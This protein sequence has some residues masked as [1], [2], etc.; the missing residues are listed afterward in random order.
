MSPAP[1]TSVHVRSRALVIRSHA[2]ALMFAV[3]LVATLAAFAAAGP[4]AS[5][6]GTW[7]VSRTAT[8]HDYIAVD[9]IDLL[10]GWAVYGTN[11]TDTH[12]HAIARTV[13]G[14]ATWA[15]VE[16]TPHSS[17]PDLQDIAFFDAT[18]GVAVGR[19][20]TVVR[21]TDGGVT[22]Q[23]V[24][25]ANTTTLH[26]DFYDVDVVSSTRAYAAGYTY[27]KKCDI[28][29]TSDGG[30]TWVDRS[31]TQLR[32][33]D[34]IELH[35]LDFV[36]AQ[37]GWAAYQNHG[38]E[39]RV[40]TTTDGGVTWTDTFVFD[41]SAAYPYDLYFLDAQNGW[42]VAGSSS[43]GMFR[44]TD[45]G[46]TWTMAGSP[47]DC[48]LGFAVFFVSPTHGYLGTGDTNSSDTILWETID[49]GT[50]WAAAYDGPYSWTSGI[51]ALDFTDANHGWAGGHL[52]QQATVLKYVGTDPLPPDTTD[53]VTTVTGATNGA[54]YRRDVVLTFNATDGGFGSSGVQGITW[55]LDLFTFG[56]VLPGGQAYFFAP[57]DHSKD[58]SYQVFYYAEDNAGNREGDVALEDRSI[59][60]G[61]DTRKPTTSAPYA[62]SARRGTTATLKYKVKET[63]AFGPKA[64]SV[65]IK[66]YKSGVLKKTLKYTT[67]AVN[68]LQSA[69][70]TVPGKWKIG[71][72]V[73]KVYATDDAGNAQ[74]SV[75]SNKLV[76][77]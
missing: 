42:L 5:A 49:G 67:K 31:P 16:L 65:T 77:K 15:S 62:T 29:M 52:F 55:Y 72:Y 11:D 14:G 73:F 54:W 9:F 38:D 30:A 8:G 48:G 1:R 27:A 21:T 3:A 20:T 17:Y 64:N 4:D 68:T 10:Q 28:V 6:A 44:T 50:T 70:F 60:F 46:A 51:H 69:K 25:P 24:V 59:T 58:G 26:G 45:G 19:G 56:F 39:L 37:R 76:V 22:W 36:D 33:V 34:G 57:T 2:L 43:A 23:S 12:T 13:D 63:G 66:V 74:A 32:T 41:H 71:T 47:A 40:L 18:T 75:G 53:P 35:A 7:S 61:I